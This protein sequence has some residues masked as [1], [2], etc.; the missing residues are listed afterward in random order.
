MNTGK[1]V[2]DSKSV[3]DLVCVNTEG[4]SADKKSAVGL[5]C[6]NTEDSAGYAKTVIDIYGLC[7]QAGT[8]V[9]RRIEGTCP[10]EFSRGVSS[11]ESPKTPM[12]PFSPAAV[13]T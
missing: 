11:E 7:Q 5:V 10:L 2:I 13:F 12:M 6:V 4:S 9:S 8:C 3:A 1:G